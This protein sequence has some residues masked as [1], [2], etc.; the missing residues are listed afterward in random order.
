LIGFWRA[1]KVLEKLKRLILLLL[2][3]LVPGNIYLIFVYAP[4][5][6]T[7]GAVQKVFYA[8][9]ASA[10]IGMLAFAVVFFFSIRYLITRERASS[11]LALASA[12]IGTVFITNVLLTGPMWAKP[13]WN[14]WWTWDPRLTTTTVMWFMYLAYLILHSG[15]ASENRR[16]LAAVYGI[17]AFI[18]VPIVF[19]SARWWRSI[20]PVVITA[21]ETGLSDLMKITLLFTLGTFTLIYLYFLA[22]RFRSLRLE[23]RINNLKGGGR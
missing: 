17:I 6:K 5:E 11:Q 23:E 4:E 16:R 20:H 21:A 3:I 12:E 14:T 19:F 2:G 7:M 13:V 15:G 18:N 8:H 10:W 1:E 9:V 22:L